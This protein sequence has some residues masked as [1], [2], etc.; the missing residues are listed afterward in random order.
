MLSKVREALENNDITCI[1]DYKRRT[2][3][4]FSKLQEISLEDLN[5]MLRTFDL[6]RYQSMEPMIPFYFQESN[7]ENRYI[8]AR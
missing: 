3:L 8:A 4:E 1:N 5:I 6:G 2:I 7:P